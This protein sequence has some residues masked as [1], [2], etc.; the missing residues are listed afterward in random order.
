MKI[1]KTRLTQIIKEELARLTEANWDHP[2]EPAGSLGGYGDSTDLYEPPE[3]TAAYYDAKAEFE[4]LVNGKVYQLTHDPL[5][6]R[7]EIPVPAVDGMPF[8]EWYEE[9]GDALGVQR[10]TRQQT[11]RSREMVRK[12]GVGDPEWDIKTD[13]DEDVW[14]HKNKS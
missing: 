5:N 13:P 1:T 4:K 3:E 7:K 14:E 11:A 12:H 6:P 2:P 8:E 9:H 10:R